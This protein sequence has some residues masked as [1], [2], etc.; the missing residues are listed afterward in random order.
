MNKTNQQIINFI[1]AVG[2]YVQAHP[3]DT[4]FK[5]ALNAVAK[6]ARKLY[7]KYAN[8][9][10]DLRIKFAAV[11][12]DNTILRNEQGGFKFTKEGL[13]AFRADSTALLE[14]EVEIEPFTAED[15]PVDLN[16][17]FKEIFEGFVL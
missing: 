7:E 11:D 10:E 14:A 17:D 3:E 9:L 5:Y 15:V 2:A 13:L 6:R 8:S 16:A 4:K 1:N 12:K